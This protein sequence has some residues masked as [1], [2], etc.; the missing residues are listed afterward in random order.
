MF[1]AVALAGIAL[2]TTLVELALLE[3]PFADVV[4]EY[5][6]EFII[7]T[8]FIIGFCNVDV[9][10]FGPAQLYVA[11]ATVVADRFNV[12]PSHNGPLLEADA[13]AGI[14]LTT[15][16]VELELLEQPFDDVVTE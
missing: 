11:P 13:L 10:P 9:K 8:L 2:T 6:P 5:D 4:T 1:D 7:A 12:D 14:A 15:T 16:L 3:Q